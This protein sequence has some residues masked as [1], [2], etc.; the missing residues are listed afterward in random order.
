MRKTRCLPHE[1]LHMPPCGSAIHTPHVR[2]I[3]HGQGRCPGPGARTCQQW[4]TQTLYSVF[5]VSVYVCGSVDIERER[6]KAI[7][8]ERRKR[9]SH[10]LTG[11]QYHP[12][13]NGSNNTRISNTASCSQICA[14][15]KC[16]LTDVHSFGVWNFIFESLSLSLF[17]WLL[18]KTQVWALSRDCQ[19]DFT[20]CRS[21]AYLCGIWALGG[22]SASRVSWCMC[23]ANAATIRPARYGIPVENAIAQ[24]WRHPT[25]SAAALRTHGPVRLW[26][27]H[28]SA[29]PHWRGGSHARH[30]CYRYGSRHG[31]GKAWESRQ[32][33]GKDARMC[34]SWI[35]QNGPLWK[36]RTRP[37]VVLRLC[38]PPQLALAYI[39]I[40]RHKDNTNLLHSRPSIKVWVFPNKTENGLYDANIDDSGHIF[41]KFCV[42]FE[43]Y[44]FCSEVYGACIEALKAKNRWFGAYVDTFWRYIEELLGFLSF[45][46]IFRSV[47]FPEL[48]FFCTTLR[49][50]FDK[51]YLRSRRAP[52]V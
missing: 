26:L 46:F 17:Y 45:H 29:R 35:L 25:S 12:I 21:H 8:N 39:F 30:S 36:Q 42:I 3:I 48:R 15:A 27:L 22:A 51:I 50:F 24:S 4:R 37:D 47:I 43:Y 7:E 16:Q 2:V 49:F 32:F 13:Q 6:D 5:S 23:I 52:G 34:G 44:T 40:T 11:V 10:L 28:E 38:M 1:R 31:M 41:E 18:V 14:K 20:G 19:C 9:D 33:A